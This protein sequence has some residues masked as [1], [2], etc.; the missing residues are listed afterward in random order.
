MIIRRIKPEELKRTEELFA[1][2]FESSFDNTKTA[3]EVADEIINHPK[4]RE[5][6][7]WQYRWAAFL[8]DDK[9]MTSYF[10]DKPYPFNFDGKTYI[11]SGIGGVATLPQYRRHGGIRKCFEAAL[12]DMYK[13]GMTF[14]YLYPFSY[15]YYRKFG[16]EMCCNAIGYDWLP[17]FF[18][19][20]F[21]VSGTCYLLDGIEVPFDEALA[22]IKKVYQSWQHKYNMMIVNEDFEY[23][24]V[25]KSNPYK[26]QVF[27]YVYRD[28]KGEAKAYISFKEVDEGTDR[29]LIAS[30]FVFTDLEGFKGILNI[31]GSLRSDH[32]HFKF[33]LPSDIYLDSVQPEWAMGGG[34]KTSVRLGM[35]RVINAQTVLENAIYKGTGSLKIAVKDEYIPENN[36]VFAVEFKDNKAVSVKASDFDGDIHNSTAEIAMTVAEFS[37]LIIGVCNTDAISYLDNVVVNKD[38]ENIGKVFYKKPIFLT[39][40]F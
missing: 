27:T 29:N 17:S 22:D 34:S 16:Y 20:S 25:K 5:D 1:I 9:T 30:R 33:T 40:Y 7:E 11:G 4:S 18:P 8:D 24:W 26:D 38:S 19:R 3:A 32:K 36:K 6:A 10:I 12:P 28:G 31:I 15:A 35:A 13:N 39:E 37:R 2:S 23:E 14:S 21:D